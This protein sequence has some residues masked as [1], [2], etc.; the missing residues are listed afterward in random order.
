MEVSKLL[1]SLSD[2]DL[3]RQTETAASQIGAV[4]GA[5]ITAY[6]I[7]LEVLITERERRAQAW[8]ESIKEREQS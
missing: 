1:T 4:L 8:L 2:A 6:R 7:L 3:R 5:R